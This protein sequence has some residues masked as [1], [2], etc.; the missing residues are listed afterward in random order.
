[1]IEQI[2][3]TNQALYHQRKF[4]PRLLPDLANAGPVSA[5]ILYAARDPMRFAQGVSK[6][7]T[8]D[9]AWGS[10]VDM[11]WLTPQDW[12]RYFTIL[13][14]DAPKK[15]SIAQR[16]AAKPSKATVDAI[17]WWD[18]WEAVSNGK[19]LIDDE[20]LQAVRAARNM[21]DAHPTSRHIWENS[22]KQIILAG[23]LPGLSPVPNVKAKCMM[24]LLPMSGEIEID[25][26][27]Y[28]L[29]D[30]LVDLKQCHR[31]DEYGMKKAIAQFEYHMKMAWYQRLTAA[32][33]GRVRPHV[34]LIFQNSRPPHDVHVRKLDPRDVEY[35]GII[36]QQRLDMMARLDHR[37]L[38]PFYDVG[39]KEISL[40]KWMKEDDDLES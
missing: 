9:M 26:I 35:G 24:D 21:L 19:M 36:A 6:K 4:N 13:P 17:A 39:I 14:A 11:L 7:K 33:E 5:S 1:M 8:D 27:N 23:D 28:D 16:R 20:T 34:I 22:E 2:Q 32:W 12:D 40:A 18:R 29:R 38:R 3:S 30:C 25:S 10:M 31:V 15:P 37:D